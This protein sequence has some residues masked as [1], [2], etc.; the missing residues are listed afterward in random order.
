MGAG[1]DDFESD[2]S[3][4]GRIR[5]NLNEFPRRRQTTKFLLRNR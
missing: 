1:G 2:R 3:A 5:V 4:V